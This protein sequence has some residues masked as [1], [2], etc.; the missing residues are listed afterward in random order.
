MSH[1][2]DDLCL[3]KP[4]TSVSKGG[5][6]TFGLKFALR[7]YDAFSYN[8]KLYLYLGIWY[9]I[10]EGIGI[11]S[12]I[13]NAFVIA[14][15][16]DFIPRL[17]YAYKYGPCAGQGRAGE[18]WVIVKQFVRVYFFT[19]LTLRS[20]GLFCSYF[21]WNDFSHVAQVYDGLRQRQP[22]SISGEWLWEEITAQDHWLRADRRSCE[23]LQVSVCVC[24][25]VYVEEKNANSAIYHHMVFLWSSHD[26]VAEHV[27][28]IKTWLQAVVLPQDG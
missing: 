10:L 27:Q 13:T 12:V 19:S 21:S 1:S 14:V 28:F 24:V 3:R 20:G 17:V 15:T 2:G 22:L 4:K 11:L 18:G 7:F 25:C 6:L 8:F 9:G 23:V 26:N 16:S 5:S